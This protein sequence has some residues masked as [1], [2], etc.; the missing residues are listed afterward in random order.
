MAGLN[1]G[2]T[3][4]SKKGIRTDRQTGVIYGDK[5]GKWIVRIKKPNGHVSTLAQF[6]NKKQAEECYNKALG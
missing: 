2:Y 5:S 3:Y 6:D 4:R 1:R